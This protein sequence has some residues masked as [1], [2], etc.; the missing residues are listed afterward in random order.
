MLETI[1]FVLE[2][3][4]AGSGVTCFGLF[5]GR[6]AQLKIRGEYREE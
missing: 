3:V 5:F 2:S 1:N 6:I 4:I